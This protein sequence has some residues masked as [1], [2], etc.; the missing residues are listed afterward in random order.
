MQAQPCDGL[1]VLDQL[2][3]DV[4]SESRTINILASL[5]VHL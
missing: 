4:Q 5:D 3:L 2:A 1:W